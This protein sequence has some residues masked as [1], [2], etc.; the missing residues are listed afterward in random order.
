MVRFALVRLA[1]VIGRLGMTAQ[2]STMRRPSA[3][4]ATFLLSAVLTF[5][6]LA[7]SV[8]NRNQ[9]I[10]ILPG[11]P[12]VLV[13]A[14]GGA[15]VL[16]EQV[17]LDVEF[18]RQAHSLTMAG[19]PLVLAI[20][21]A[22]VHTLVAVRVA[23]ALV[24]L[25]LQ[26]VSADKIFYNLAAYGFEIAL[27]GYLAGLLVGHHRHLSLP[28]FAVVLGVVIVVDQLMSSC[29]LVVIRMHA[30][31]LGR[32]DVLSVLI[33]ACGITIVSSA[34]AA[35]I[36]VL[37]DFAGLFGLL[38]VA[39]IAAVAAIGYRGYAATS[40]RHQGLEQVHT[41]VADGV[42]VDSVAELTEHLLLRIRTML[43]AGRVELR[44]PD[45]AA[46]PYSGLCL[47]VGEHGALRTGRCDSDPSDWLTVRAYSTGEP[48]LLPRN[49]K[50]RAVRSWLAARGLR[51]AILM[52]LSATGVTGILLVAD[53]LGERAG[54]DAEDVTLLQ[55][56]TG[57]LSVALRSTRLVERLSYDASHD[58][59]TGLHNR[60]HLSEQIHAAAG[61]RTRRSAVLLLDLDNFKEVNDTYG[62]D[63][64]DQLLKV[65]AERI[66]AGVPADATVA[67][68]GGDEFAVLLPDVTGIDAVAEL[69]EELGSRLTGPV[70]LD[71]ARLDPRASIG[72]AVAERND[73]DPDLLRQADTA[74]YTSKEQHITVSVYSVAM[75]QARLERLA[76][77]ADLRSSLRTQREQFTV[78]YQPKIKLS[79]GSVCGAEA[80]IRWMHPR[81]GS[82]SPDRFIPLAESTGLIAELTPLVLNAALAECAR[83][84]ARGHALTV[85]VNLSARNIE[86]PL[87]PERVDRA[88]LRHH[89][90]PGQLIL[91]ITESSVMGD[92]EQTIPVLQKLNRLGVVL[93]L[94]DFGTGYSSLSYL[95]QLPVQEV[96]IDRSFVVGLASPT[97][98]SS[99]ALIHSITGLGRTLDLRIVAEGVE[100][101]QR[102][103]ELAELGCDVAQGYHISRPLP[104]EDFLAWLD[105][106]ASEHSP[107]LRLLT[108]GA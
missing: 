63:A 32:G 95:Q 88:L 20:L 68:L 54:F 52:P 66:R 43:N 64:G 28:A 53:R 94:D 33:P 61:D 48:V 16:T 104:A 67:R 10:V 44:I 60:A 58:P 9:P 69:A 22:P 100:D 70:Q 56:L 101:A 83:W 108:R 34:F 35:V 47:S 89:V 11:N 37:I 36:M 96:K 103:H 62:H 45:G 76:L 15:F 98:T 38:L 55:T 99:R 81:L 39:V 72:V 3:Q 21:L 40:R 71:E 93:S 77:L 14:L 4:Q 87:L 25:L 75:D 50:D 91:E 79:D 31:P 85:A 78:H 29:V 82:V 2:G 107:A 84:K 102:L 46:E 8:A 12:L 30:G 23:A 74:M 1:L 19:V 80:L 51:D 26:R 73:D 106:R 13:A 90:D 6:A 42:G 86:D 24:A 27:S 7:L 5:G 49:T 41:F 92:P 57:H 105:V 65:V 17:M 59:L 97:P 18:R